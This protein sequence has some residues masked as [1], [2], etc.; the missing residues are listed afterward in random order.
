M[1]KIKKQLTN[2]NKLELAALAVEGFTGVVGGSLVF[3]QKYPIAS[4]MVL[5]LGMAANKVLRY[6]SK[7]S[8]TTDTC[9]KD[10]NYNQED[11]V[12]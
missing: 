1:K 2:M 8:A 9:D 7:S 4:L 3:A 10:S 11:F 12:D 6:L 5:G